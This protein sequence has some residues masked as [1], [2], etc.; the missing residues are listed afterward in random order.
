MRDYYIS[1]SPEPPTREHASA[2][3]VHNVLLT[4]DKLSVW[5]FE[6]VTRLLHRR[7]QRMKS[8]ITPRILA[9][10]AFVWEKLKLLP[11]CM[12]EIFNLY[13]R[14]KESP[15]LRVPVS[16]FSDARR[17]S[18]SQTNSTTE[19]VRRIHG[20]AMLP[21]GSRACDQVSTRGWCGYFAAAS[22]SIS[23]P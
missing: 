12:D 19:R 13:A 3:T 20:R 5:C 14:T 11:P 23:T 22:S 17:P 4:I 18:N 6:I 1:P 8:M 2:H 15:S 7:K 10:L 21:S 16:S 9:L